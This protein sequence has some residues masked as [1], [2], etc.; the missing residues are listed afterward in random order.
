MRYE[1]ALHRLCRGAMSDF[2]SE[3]SLLD[4]AVRYSGKKSRI[5]TR[6]ESQ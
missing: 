6:E 4:D 3:H 1:E 5:I 2:K